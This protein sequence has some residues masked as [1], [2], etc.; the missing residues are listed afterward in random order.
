MFIESIDASSYAKDR[1]KMFE[2]FNSFVKWIGE[3]NIV[4]VVANNASANV[5]ARKNAK[6]FVTSFEI[7]YWSLLR[8]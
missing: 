8:G 3:A 1:K 6:Y 2:L 5:L 4:Q 7:S